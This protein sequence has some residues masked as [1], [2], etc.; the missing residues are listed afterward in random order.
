MNTVSSSV[1]NIVIALLLT[2]HYLAQIITKLIIIVD[3]RPTNIPSGR[4]LAITTTK[5]YITSIVH[6]DYIVIEYLC[7]TE[8]SLRTKIIHL[9]T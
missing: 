7:I 2:K 5:S 9:S 1:T 4:G 3:S 8:G 6:F